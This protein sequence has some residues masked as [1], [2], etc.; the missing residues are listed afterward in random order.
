MGGRIHDKPAEG[1]LSEE[2]VRSVFGP[3][4][5]PNSQ[6]GGIKPGYFKAS[7]AKQESGESIEAW[8]C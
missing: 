5:M 8:F 1:K 4:L 3:P 6:K 2:V 7:T